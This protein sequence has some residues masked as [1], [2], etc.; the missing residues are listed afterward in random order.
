MRIS[1]RDALNH[2]DAELANMRKWLQDDDDDD[3]DF[4]G[5]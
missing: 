5:R 2:G 1:R 3:A 4:V